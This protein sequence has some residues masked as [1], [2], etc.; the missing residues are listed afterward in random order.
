MHYNNQTHCM[1]ATVLIRS[2]TSKLTGLSMLL[3]LLGFSFPALAQDPD[4]MTLD[5]AKVR[6]SK[7]IQDYVWFAA[8]PKNEV[9]DAAIPN[10][11][12][13]SGIVADYNPRFPD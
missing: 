3:L 10:L 4:T 13:K 11:H 2:L 7:A 9:P 1:T 6:F 5:I 12:F 8:R